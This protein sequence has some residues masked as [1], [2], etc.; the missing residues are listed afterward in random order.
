MEGALTASSSRRIWNSPASLRDPNRSESG[1]YFNVVN[2]DSESGSRRCG[3]AWLR[4]AA[5]DDAVG[6]VTARESV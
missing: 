5:R 6:S 2:S 1:L 3:L 4:P